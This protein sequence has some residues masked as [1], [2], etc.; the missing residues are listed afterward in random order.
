MSL[1]AKNFGNALA[2]PPNKLTTEAL[3]SSI[4][5]LQSPD[6]RKKAEEMQRLM[7]RVAGAKA[8]AKQIEERYLHV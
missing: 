1:I 3:S 6:Y 7:K 8:A 2:L 5:K 4:K